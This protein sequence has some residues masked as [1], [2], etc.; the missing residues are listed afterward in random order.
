MSDYS[1]PL[2]DFNFLSKEVFGLPA[3][4]A[5]NPV[6]NERNNGDTT[7]AM[8][9]ECGKISNELIAPLYRN[10][11]EEGC[12]I[13]DGLVATPQ[14]YQQAN[15]AYAEGGWG[16]LTGNPD[17]GAMDIP[18]ALAVQCEEMIAAA[19]ISFALLPLL[20]TG[21]CLAIE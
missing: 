8:L 3:Q 10:A 15:K 21:A 9:N 4:W 11:D 19:D 13:M 12:L 6:L 20:T 16:G 17:F 18:K 14:G 5:L 7:K 1:A 2:D